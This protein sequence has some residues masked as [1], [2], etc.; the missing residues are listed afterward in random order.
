MLK[1]PT[2]IERVIKKHGKK[3]PVLVHRS[4]SASDAT[5]HLHRLASNISQSVGCRF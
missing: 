2:F 5:A 1:V 3:C 4:E